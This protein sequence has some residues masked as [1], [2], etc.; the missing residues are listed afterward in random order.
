MV[1]YPILCKYQYLSKWKY[2][3]LLQNGNGEMLTLWE[4]I[5]KLWTIRI[6]QIWQQDF[7]GFKAFPNH[8]A[9]LSDKSTIYKEKKLDFEYYY[10]IFF[11]GFSEYSCGTMY[12]AEILIHFAKV[13][14]TRMFDEM[15]LGVLQNLKLIKSCVDD[16]PTGPIEIATYLHTLWLQQK[17]VQIKSLNHLNF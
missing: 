17:Y 16:V 1:I 8:L 13:L 11:N 15:K 10:A 12:C 9:A 7:T 2:Y 5:N 6:W 4:S 14:Q 3:L